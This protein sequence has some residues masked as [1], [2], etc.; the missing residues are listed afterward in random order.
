[1]PAAKLALK[2]FERGETLALGMQRIAD[3]A[4]ME[5]FGESWY[6]LLFSTTRIGQRS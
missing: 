6:W 3:V 1:M 2:R 4:T 5:P